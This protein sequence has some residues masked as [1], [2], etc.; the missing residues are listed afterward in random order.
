MNAVRRGD[1][2][3]A[4]LG[5][6]DATSAAADTAK[7]ELLTELFHGYPVTALTPL[8]RSEDPSVVKIAAWLVS[9]MGEN[10]APVLGE[11][12]ALLAHPERT[13][14]FFALDAVMTSASPSDG[15]IVAEAI[16]LIDDEQSAVRMKAMRLLAVVSAPVLRAGLAHLP[17]GRL[18]DLTAWSA[19]VAEGHGEI[20]RHLELLR[21]LEPLERRFAAAAALRVAPG[22][23]RPL[24]HASRSDDPDIQVFASRELP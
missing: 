16:A 19:E 12:A 24:E 14:R 4:L 6:I 11:V 20:D 23:R 9:E 1:E 17:P 13:A 2:L 15:R 8:M 5:T 10:A 21:G 18:R 7:M 3:V 22:D